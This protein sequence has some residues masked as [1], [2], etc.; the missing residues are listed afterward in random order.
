MVGTETTTFYCKTC[1]EQLCVT[2]TCEQ[3]HFKGPLIFGKKGKKYGD[4]AICLKHFFYDSSMRLNEALHVLTNQVQFVKSLPDDVVVED[5]PRFLE[6]ESNANQIE[7]LVERGTQE[8]G[9][10]IYLAQEIIR[11]KF[12]NQK[13]RKGKVLYKM[14]SSLTK[15][16]SNTQMPDKRF[17]QV[18][19]RFKQNLKK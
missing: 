12:D 14:K 17:T 2:T 6:L 5:N 8:R 19:K 11:S 18:R 7:K 13:T 16:T 3:Q 4:C 1:K 10:I 15:L 9:W